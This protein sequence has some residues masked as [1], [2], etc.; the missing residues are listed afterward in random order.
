MAPTSSGAAYP[1][2]GIVKP[3]K[4]GVSLALVIAGLA[5]VP[6]FQ[7]QAADPAARANGDQSLVQRMRAEA[8]DG[9]RLAMERSTGK[10]GFVRA[11]GHG[12]L[13]PSQSARSASGAA[14]KAT[15][16]LDKYAPAF[17]ADAAQ[18][19]PA[20]I[21]AT[22]YGWTV[23]YAQTYQGVPVFGSQL[24]ANLDKAGDLTSVNGFVAPDLD[25]SVTPR[26]TRQQAEARALSM[27]RADPP[28]GRADA[29]ADISGLKAAS[30]TL[31]IYRMGAIKGEKGDNI[32]A[33]VIEVTNHANVRDMVF[34]DAATGKVVNRYSM[35]DTA[36]ER[37]LI[38]AAG[39]SD[40]STFTEVWA[41]GDPFPG[42]LDQAQQDLVQSS[43]DAYWFFKDTF[44]RDSYDGAGHSM[45]T[46][47]NDGRIDCPNANWNG[48]TTNYCDGVTSDDTVAHE[49]AHAYTEYTSGLIY[50]WQPGAMNE[51]FSD[52]WGETVDM[53]N[54]R[55]NDTPDTVR[56]E[57]QCSKYTRGDV[58]VTIN[59][60]ADIAGPCQA[61]PAQFGPVFDKTGVT[62]DVVVGQD[63]A[64]DGGTPTDG[65]SPFSNAAALAGKFVY[66]DRGACTFAT[67]A[68]NAQDAGATGIIIGN[69]VP[70]A[71]FSPS[72]SADIYGVMIDQASGAKIKGATGTVN[73]TI[74]DIDEAP[75]ADSYRWLS[76]E[77]DPAFGGAIRDLWNPNCY[78]DPGK[79]TDAQYW[80]STDDAGG[81]HTNSGVVNH[82]FALLVDGSTSNGVEVTGLGLDKAANVFWRAQT[83]YLTPTSGFADLATALTASCTDLVGQPINKVQVTPDGTPT[84]ADSITAADCTAV[85]AATEATELRTPPTQCNFQPMLAKNA[86]GLCG[87]R[88]RTK[89]FWKDT[90]EKGL[91]KWSA[92]EKVV[93]DGGHGYKWRATTDVPGSHGTK[94]AFDPAPDEGDCSAGP[95]D[96]SSANGITSPK[97]TMP[98][99]GARK[100][101][102]QH[103]MAT[104]PGYDGGNVKISVNGKKFTVI[105]K[106]AYLYN[107][108]TTTIATEADGNTNPLAGEQG[109]TGTDGGVAFGSWGTSIIDLRKAGAKPGDKVKVR[110]ELGRDG[111]GGNDGW[112]VDNVRFVICLKKH[113]R[114]AATLGRSATD[115]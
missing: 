103:Y 11:A 18:L 38:E 79:V 8:S 88:F 52:I 67:K 60:P 54:D 33:W 64:D 47:N 19:R 91:G 87:N 46:V 70:D 57:G 77:G 23:R 63:A 76:G 75:K 94:V 17:G 72:G 84:A 109:F 13:M 29:P 31:S 93:Y 69:N 95:G 30:T 25:L 61:A 62:T 107:G 59:S 112:Y 4:T 43:G 37:H 20:G 86:P 9:A 100:L 48:Q 3:I 15:A 2:G 14:A 114:A 90:F 12:D 1:L 34:L 71:P 89:T 44:G 66:V 58:G 78:G 111:C 35:L 98:R 16:Y 80:C 68:A 7:A 106:W 81:V 36:L 28:T 41:E 49:W 105:P 108:P 39:S 104:E 96:I 99:G 32:L 85:Q 83:A 115:S 53:T 82:T 6:A 26:F 110:F 101:S 27:V 5:A 65:C 113:H 50:Q 97:I 92:S 51:A 21:D 42:T 73:V 56:P 22:R 55:Q 24:M 45:T 40:P 10:V 74:K 102:F